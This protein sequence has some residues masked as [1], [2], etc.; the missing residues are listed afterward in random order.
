MLNR[1]LII[2]DDQDVRNIL[3]SFLSGAGYTVLEAE[4]GESGLEMAVLE[5]PDLI[6]LDINMP[7]MDGIEV[8]R[9]LRSDPKNISAIIMITASDENEV[10]GLESGADDYVVK[11]FQKKVLL[12]RIKRGLAVAERRQDAHVDPLTNV[13]NRRTFNTFLVQEEERATRYGRPLAMIMADV[14]HFKVVNDTYGHDVGDQV[15]IEMANILRKSCRRSDLLARLGGEEFAILLPE[16]N[17]EAG[18][19]CAEKARQRIEDHLFPQDLRLTA[20]FGVAELRKNNQVG[21]I[22]RADLAMYD[23]K[24]SGRNRVMVEKPFGMEARAVS[25]LVID[26]DEAIRDLIRVKMMYRGYDVAVAQNGDA[27]FRVLQENDIDLVLIDQEMPGRDGMAT[28]LAI[29]DEW[30]QLPAIMI[31]AHGSKHLIKSFLVSGGRDF[32]EKPIV[33][34]ESFDFRVKRVLAELRKE[35]E[36]EEKI[37][38]SKVREESRKIKDVFLASMSH[39]LRT[40]LAHIIGFTQRLQKADCTDPE[41]QRVFL[42][43]IEDAAQSLK[44]IVEDILDVTLIESHMQCDSE[45]I[46]LQSVVSKVADKIT[47]TLQ[48]KAI[49]LNISVPDN[50]PKVHADGDKLADVFEKLIGNAVKFTEGG[51][52]TINA[53]PMPNEVVVSVRDTGCGISQQKIARLFEPFGKLDHETGNKAGTGLGLYICRRLIELMGGKIWVNSEEGK[54]TTFFFSLKQDKEQ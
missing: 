35:Q 23:A 14:D 24:D 52:I 47:D 41:K 51:S 36:A 10:E 11:P 16:S 20:S 13:F 31:T 43:K 30:P 28:F 15:L 4:D 17:A 38:A 32:I 49:T 39:E 8:C 53:Q 3:Q 1:I 48:T 27:A 12:A 45:W 5:Q 37:R 26:D 42:D 21:M 7:G 22:K 18:I 33:D 50:L 2:D 44:R 25:L 40:P 19:I 6:L 54:G 29:K 46:S 34:F 9:K